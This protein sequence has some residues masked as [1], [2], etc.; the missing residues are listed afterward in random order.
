MELLLTLPATGPVAAAAI[1]AE[2][3]VDMSRF[4]KSR[5]SRVVGWRRALYHALGYP[6]R[7][8]E[9]LERKFLGQWLTSC[10][11]TLGDWSMP[12]KAGEHPKT[13]REPSRKTRAIG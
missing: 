3:G 8:Q 7:S 4:R 12:L 13:L 5:S 11:K 10:R 2:I 9:E 1:I 6:W